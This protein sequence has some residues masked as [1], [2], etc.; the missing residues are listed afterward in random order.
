MKPHDSVI[1]IR[2]RSSLTNHEIIERAQTAFNNIYE[3]DLEAVEVLEV[4][5]DEGESL[6]TNRARKDYRR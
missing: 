5:L 2:L 6:S 4:T 1:T 3:E